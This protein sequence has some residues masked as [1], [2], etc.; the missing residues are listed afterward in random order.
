M[1]SICPRC[2]VIYRDR[3]VCPLCL[4]RLQPLVPGGAAVVNPSAA[5]VESPHESPPGLVVLGIAHGVA[6]AAFLRFLFGVLLDLH[7]SGTLPLWATLPAVVYLSMTVAFLALSCF[8]LLSRS[9][10]AEMETRRALGLLLVLFP[11]GTIWGTAWLAYLRRISRAAAVVLPPP[12]PPH[13]QPVGSSAPL[14]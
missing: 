6:A 1:E 14:N 2:N 5:V 13:P 9:E 7:R 8:G 11:I 4:A 3:T 10:W 12:S